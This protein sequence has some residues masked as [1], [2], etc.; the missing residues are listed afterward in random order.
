MNITDLILEKGEYYQEEN[1]KNTIYL[2]HT[3][4][5]HRA[6][7]VISTWDTDDEVDKTGT[8]SPRS[9]ATA[10]VIGGLST[11]NP[12]DN[13][14]D[15]KVYRAF[16]DKYWA[17]HLG[18][19]LSNNRT[20]NKESVAVEICNYG[21]LTK[22]TDGKFYTY[23]NTVVPSNMVVQLEKPF[24]GHRYYH[25]Y[26][27]KQITATRDFILEMKKKYHKIELR[28]PLLT[29]EGFEYNISATKGLA[30]IYCHSNVRKDKFDIAPQPKMIAMLQEICSAF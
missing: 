11:R 27:D 26:T 15:G 2:H 12:K 24:R 20:L 6:D 10:Y 1:E 4:G 17:H 18:T 5:G 28:T 14:F 25:A 16:D 7:W 9:V 23:V 29:V 30:G 13:L 22:G 21:Q 3:A 19:T 8:K